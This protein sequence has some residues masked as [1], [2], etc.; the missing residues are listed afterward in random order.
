M[1]ALAVAG[2]FAYGLAV[3]FG[4]LGMLLEDDRACFVV[5]SATAAAGT[6]AWLLWFALPV[7]A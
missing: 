6:T 2:A 7:Y 4:S 1:T 3:L 5:S